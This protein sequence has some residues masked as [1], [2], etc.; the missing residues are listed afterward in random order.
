MRN[1]HRRSAGS[2]RAIEDRAL[3]S[4]E[5]FEPPPVPKS[6]IDQPEAVEANDGVWDRV[7]ERVG[8]F[9][10]PPVPA[11]ISVIPSAVAFPDAS[12]G[13]NRS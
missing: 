4:T 8:A 5:A 11:M 9:A 7:P 12:C 2:G 13:A 1:R 6:Q 3:H 10:V